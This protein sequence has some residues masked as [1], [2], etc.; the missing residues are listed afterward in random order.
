MPDSIPGRTIEGIIISPASIVVVGASDNQDKIGG[1]PL[2]F[3]QKHG[4]RG[5]LYAVNPNRSTVQSVPSF[6][7]IEAL[8]EAPELAY[9]AVAG[10]EAVKA[11]QACAELG[12]KAALIISSGFGE[13][14]AA[15]REVQDAMVRNARAKGMRI[16]GPN[17]QGLANFGSG[18]IASFCTM[19]VEIEPLDGPVAIV[20]QSGAMCQVAYGQL[21]ERGIGVR[22]VHATGNEADIT[23]SDLACAVV[24]DPA[25]KVLLLYVEAIPDP[26]RL[27]EAA[28]LARER[29]VAIVA[30]KSGRTAQGAK[31]ATSH[32]GAMANED[33][34]FDAFLRQHGIWRA[35]DTHEQ[36]RCVE[37]Y[38]KGW[39][40]R[41]RNL[42]I[43]SNSGASCVMGADIASDAGLP[44]A[45][46]ADDTQVE[47]G[48]RLPGFAATANPI[49]ITAALLSN[50]GLFG[51]VLP[52]VQHDRAAHLVFIQ[53]PVS[54]AAYDVPRF[55]A[56]TAAF[57]EASGL[58][59][60]VCTWQESA[61][62]H[63]RAAGIPTYR[64]ARDAI[65][66]LAQLAVHHE[67]IDKASVAAGS[68]TPAVAAGG[69]TAFLS[70]AD[71]LAR[72][73]SQGVPVIGHR[74]CATAAE[75][76]SAFDALGPRVVVKACSA[77]VPHKS[78]HGL[79]ALGVTSADDA[80]RHFVDHWGKLVAL[81][82]ADNA[83]VV[84]TMARGQREF[85][86]GARRDPVFGPVVVIGDGGKYV[87][88]LGDFELLL[89]PF[90]KDE[91]IAAL[92]R[93]RIAPLLDGVRGDPPLDLDALADIAVRIGH[94]M[95]EAS[96]IFSIDVN[97][98]L[99]QARGQGAIV[100]DALVETCTGS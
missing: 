6:P 29:G 7:S 50:S 20:S 59:V 60:A 2:F 39:K 71:S 13:V 99:V 34:V 75:A 36:L 55:A 72:L 76:R 11:V 5:R 93:L 77:E 87:E 53:I 70:E 100:V 78:E 38:L 32:T 4:Y 95:N 94:L 92:R 10:D 52:V 25:V 56:D 17:S 21:R 86:V 33:R 37:M 73:A 82:V 8:P 84:A 74:V 14:D 69:P 63:F 51:S 88:A 91:V 96:D 40:P 31:A 27:A 64:T 81:D 35:A 47:L 83:I 24:Q 16:I 42:V 58:P 30:I 98:V 79:V 23:V 3:M 48:K 67:L 54:G 44:L 68:G 97:P 18:A 22:H 45:T 19:F 1:R 65:E 12:V 41:G 90:G 15:G 66:A 26:H 28:R 80:A 61:A 62:R 43:I 46:L 57:A 89:P 49:D 85:M 9:I